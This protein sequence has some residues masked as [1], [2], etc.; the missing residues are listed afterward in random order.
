MSPRTLPLRVTSAEQAAA[1]DRAAIAA[2][3]A[4][5]ELM[6]RAGTRSAELILRELSDRLEYGVAVFAGRGNNGGDAYILA[7]QLARAGIAVHCVAAG[8]PNTD[9]ARRAQ[10]LAAARGVEIT[11]QCDLPHTATARVVVDGLLGTGHRGEF[12][13]D[14]LPF[15]QSLSAARARGASVVALDIPSGLNATS[16]ECADGVVAADI[17][18]TFGTVKRGLLSARQLTGRLVLVDIGLPAD[19]APSEAWLLADHHLAHAFVPSMAWNAHKGTRGKLLIVGGH[20]GMAGATILAGQGALHAG[21]GL[22]QACVDT[23]SLSA[24]QHELPQAIASA[25]SALDV[26]AQSTAN[27]H[28]SVHANEQTNVHANVR[29]CV[30]GPGLGSSLRSERAML[31]ALSS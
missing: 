26:I 8:S 27:V 15:V 1:F 25:W 13:P 4:S 29:A 7:A 5:F 31:A 23:E 2:G 17:T 20:V 10:G 28:A 11:S 18:T 9:D 22:V 14:L 24:V 21:A 3:T 30:I 19:L 16:G 6:L 12:R